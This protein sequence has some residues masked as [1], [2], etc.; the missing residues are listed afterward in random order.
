[1]WT[2][3][4]PAVVL[5]RNSSPAPRVRAYWRLDALPE[6]E[7]DLQVQG[8]DNEK[9]EK[10]KIRIAINNHEI[11]AGPVVFPKNQWAWRSY[12]V[13]REYLKPGENVV[14]IENITQDYSWGWCMVSAIKLTGVP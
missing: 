5:R 2:T 6:T 13:P 11:A 9:K 4:R 10:A 8:L 7:A 14:V 3:G 1:M 12:K